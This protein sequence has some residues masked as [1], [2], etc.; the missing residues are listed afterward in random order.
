MSFMIYIFGIIVLLSG[1]IYGA[2]LLH[3]PQQWIAVGSIVIAGLGILS[4][5]SRTRSRDKAP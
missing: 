4:A 2:F 3:V 1:F 5:V